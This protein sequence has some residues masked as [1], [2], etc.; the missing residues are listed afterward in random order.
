L[1]PRHRACRRAVADPRPVDFPLNPS[2]LLEYLEVLRDGRLRERHRVDDCSADTLPTL[3]QKAEDRGPRRMREAPRE[4]REIIVPLRG[5]AASPR[6]SR[7]LQKT[8]AI[9]HG[10]ASWIGTPIQNR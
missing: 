7:A 3:E 8:D 9:D 10:T 4:A 1:E 6:R 2:G 5:D